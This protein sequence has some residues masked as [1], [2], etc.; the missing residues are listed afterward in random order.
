M[1]NHPGRPGP[2][3]PPEICV[4]AGPISGSS[5]S[6]SWFLFAFRLFCEMQAAT[7]RLVSRVLGL[8]N[9]R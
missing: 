6:F 9:I 8:G 1:S 3:A 5:G 7:L 2:K 4:N